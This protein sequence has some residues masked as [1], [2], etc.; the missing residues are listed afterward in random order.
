[1]KLEKQSCID[2]LTNNETF[3]NEV[4][5]CEASFTE[6]TRYE[7]GGYDVQHS[8]PEGSPECSPGCPGQH[9]VSPQGRIYLSLWDYP[10]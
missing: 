8:L 6:G 3:V 5:A 9:Y 10:E 7:D 1:M 2:S 4:N